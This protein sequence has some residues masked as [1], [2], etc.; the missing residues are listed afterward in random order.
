MNF[1]LFVAIFFAICYLFGCLSY[2]L[3]RFFPSTRSPQQSPQRQGEREGKGA[4]EGKTG[5][6]GEREEK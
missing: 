4:R 3:T 5:S 2:M 1:K 6:G